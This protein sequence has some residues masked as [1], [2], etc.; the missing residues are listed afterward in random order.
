MTS[1]TDF[2][3]QE[4]ELVLSGPPTAGMMV[5]TADHGGMMRETFAMA[6]AYAEARQQHGASRLLDDIVAAKPQMERPHE[7]SIGEFREH[8]LQALRDA[9]ALLEAKAAPEEVDE[10]RRFVLD[11]TDRVARRHKEHGAEVSDNE[12]AVIDAISEA[13]SGAA[14]V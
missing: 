9:V 1:K 11:L 4:W 5:I 12:Q 6:K 3:E 13:L 14:A 7:G 8:G 2:T 10:Y